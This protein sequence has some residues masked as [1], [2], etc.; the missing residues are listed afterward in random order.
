MIDGSGLGLTDS[1]ILKDV[2]GRYAEEAYRAHIPYSVGA[3]LHEALSIWEGGMNSMIP[4][5]K[6]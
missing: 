3:L 6:L 1:G 4:C 5:A 2:L